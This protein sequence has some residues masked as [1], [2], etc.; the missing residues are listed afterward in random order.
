MRL[1]DIDLRLLR[2]FIAVA[3]A[4]G[5][6]KAQDTLGIS[7]P[8]ISAQIAKLEDRLNIRLCHRGPQGFSL[9]NLGADVLRE[10]QELM[11]HVDASAGRLLQIGRKPGV[12]IRLGVVDCMITD[13]AN[14]IVP[15]L[16]AFRQKRPNAEIKIGVYDLLDCMNELRAGRID[17]AIAGIADDEV[18][19]SDLDAA[20]LYEEKSHLYC[21]P[22]HPC[23][24]A[25]DA[26]SLKQALAAANISAYSFLSNPIGHEFDVDLMDHDAEIPQE[27][28]ES[29]VYLALCGSHVG[30]IPQHFAEGWVTSGA[31][32]QIA[33]DSYTIIS[34]FHGLRAKSAERSTH[35]SEFWTC[36]IAAGADAAN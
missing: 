31:L 29:T 27:T 21:A 6:A 1:S 11:D 12:Q 28:I 32:V 26:A 23:A 35:T 9:T 14:P 25:H 7:Q 5:F 3:E 34:K 2:V 13:P 33:D 15:A 24:G 18:V 17:F 22:D 8:A 30:L 20:A 4:G 36:L 16:K 10:A 19:P